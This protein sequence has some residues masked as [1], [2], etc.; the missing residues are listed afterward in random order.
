MKKRAQITA[1]APL[2]LSGMMLVLIFALLPSA[3][4]S[5]IISDPFKDTYN[6]GELIPVTTSLKENFDGLGVLS[7]SIKC[8]EN[9]TASEITLS[10]K[11]VKLVRGEAQQIDETLTTLSNSVGMCKI[12]A[13]LEYQTNETVTEKSETKQF[14]VSRE[15]LGS[16]SAGQSAIQLGQSNTIKGRVS[17]LDGKMLK[18]TAQLYFKKDSKNY[19][20]GIVNVENGDFLYELNSTNYPSGDYIFDILAKD[21]V[22]NEKSFLGASSFKVSNKI[23]VTANVNKLNFNPGEK[24]GV[25]G[26]IEPEIPSYKF[27]NAEISIK[28]F[29]DTYLIKSGGDFSEEVQVPENAKS[30]KTKIAVKALDDAG[31]EGMQEIEISI[32][33]IPKT[34]Q[35]NLNRRTFKPEENITITPLVFDQANDLAFQSVEVKIEDAVRKTIFETEAKTNQSIDYQLLSGAIPGNYKITAK[36]GALEAEENIVVESVEKIII[37]LENQTILMNN[38]G[39]VPYKEKLS[40]ELDGDKNYTLT[41]NL[42]ISPGVVAQMDLNREIPAGNYLLKIPNSSL[43]GEQLVNVSTVDE[44]SFL[45]KYWGIPPRIIGQNSIYASPFLLAFIALILSGLVA[46]FIYRQKLM[47][48]YSFGKKPEDENEDKNIETIEAEEMNEFLRYKREKIVKERENRENHNQNNNHNAHPERENPE[49][50]KFIKTTLEKHEKEKI[51]RHHSEKNASEREKPE[52]RKFI[53]SSL[54]AQKETEEKRK[55]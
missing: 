6:V 26:K 5:L 16:F 54:K 4:A 25:S 32:Q 35:L 20:V 14:I 9:S 15:L 48:S 42:D 51:E 13:Q 28:L 8:I 18:G 1:F 53:E 3:F 45:T 44:R 50:R 46:G 22:G 7:L 17:Y 33:Q 12:T 30:G 10:M 38:T 40:F 23:S 19:Y 2:I 21:S 27:R 24:I 41:K 52:V 39:N 55:K 36:A 11:N 43:Q 47:A 37:K 31:N 49:V 29:N 34:V